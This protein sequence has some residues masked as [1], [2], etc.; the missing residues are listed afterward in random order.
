MRGEVNQ[1]VT[2][3]IRALVSMTVSERNPAWQELG[4]NLRFGSRLMA[5][6]QVHGARRTGI[7]PERRCIAGVGNPVN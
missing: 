7:N 5:N 4:V 6:Y 3:P 2:P 1:T